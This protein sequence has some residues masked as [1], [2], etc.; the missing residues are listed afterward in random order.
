[1]VS[2]LCGRRELGIDRAVEVK[3]HEFVR[4]PTQGKV[5][6]SVIEQNCHSGEKQSVRRSFPIDS[7]NSITRHSSGTPNGAL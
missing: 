6:F 5:T 4:T 1:M 2:G 7:D 3:S